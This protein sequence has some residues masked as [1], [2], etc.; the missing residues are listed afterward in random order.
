MVNANSAWVA[1]F[2]AEI[3][4][5]QLPFRLFLFRGKANHYDKENVCF[6]GQGWRLTSMLRFHP[7]ANWRADWNY[8]TQGD[9]D[10]FWE[11]W[12]FMRLLIK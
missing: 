4:H 3:T 10:A 6:E 7:I 11:A 2:T 5:S 1:N 9:R 12:L 8:H